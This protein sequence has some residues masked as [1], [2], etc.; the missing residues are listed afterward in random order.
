MATYTRY[1][2]IINGEAQFHLDIARGGIDAIHES[3]HA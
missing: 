1:I 3:R 2:A